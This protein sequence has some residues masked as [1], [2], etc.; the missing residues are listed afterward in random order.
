[1]RL[2]SA[3]VDHVRRTKPAAPACRGVLLR[4]TKGF[5][6]PDGV[7]CDPVAELEAALQRV[8]HEL[9]SCA[10][11][12]TAS[13]MVRP[14]RSAIARLGSSG[15]AGPAHAVNSEPQFSVPARNTRARTAAR[16]ARQLHDG[17]VAGPANRS[18][19]SGPS[20]RSPRFSGKPSSPSN[21]PAHVPLIRIGDAGS[22]ASGSSDAS[23]AVVALVNDAV[24]ALAG[25]RYRDPD[26]AIGLVLGTGACG[27]AVAVRVSGRHSNVANSSM[28]CS[29]TDWRRTSL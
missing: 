9:D 13:R 21:A 15:H 14:V 11:L 8:A 22:E 28:P 23:G 6:C 10:E 18:A 7:G 12:A 16:S 20:A 27:R 5:A 19:S 17:T 3:L 25:A 26:V 2:T 29:W 1:M 4:W 24:A